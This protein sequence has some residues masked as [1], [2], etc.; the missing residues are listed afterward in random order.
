MLFWTLL[1]PIALSTLF[2]VAIFPT[3]K[4]FVFSAIP[5]AVVK[6]QYNEPESGSAI[7]SQYNELDELEGNELG[8]QLEE[9]L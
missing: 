3:D 4:D 9:V 5:A 8:E 2:R 1:F 7:Q 6:S